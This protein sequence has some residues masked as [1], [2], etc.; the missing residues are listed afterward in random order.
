[1]KFRVVPPVAPD[2]SVIPE[3]LATVT[4]LSNPTKTRTMTLNEL[5]DNEGPIAALLNGMPYEGAPITELP[6]LGTTEMWEVVNMT[7]DT[8][9]IHIH[10]V[11]FQILN[12]QRI[13]AKRYEMAFTSA[14]P[15][16]P[17]E[18]YTEVP[19]GPYVKG[20]PTPADANERGWKDNLPD[21]SG[22]G[23]AGADSLGA[24]GREPGVR[25]RRHGRAGIR[26]ALPHPRARGER[27]D[28]AVQ[29]G[30]SGRACAGRSPW[31]GL[32]VRSA[33]RDRTSGRR[34][35]TPP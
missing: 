11:Q 3:Q 6:E 29:A 27:H 24:P 19:V 2:N 14:N 7:G 13:N 20:K 23:D 9:P 16:M 10:L 8:H 31:R 21:E 35:R 4:R 1:M 28:A 22:R 32:R 17:A 18:T 26:M 25:L 15:V 12:R 33:G 5:Q 34:L 30:G